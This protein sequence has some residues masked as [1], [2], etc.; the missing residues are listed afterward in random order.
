MKVRV[1]LLS[2]VGMLA[3]M[4]VLSS[5]A[6]G[7]PAPAQS[8]DGSNATSGDIIVTAQRRA[9]SIQTV[10]LSVTALNG[11]DLKARGLNDLT[12]ISLAAPSL[13]ITNNNNFSV[14][15]IGTLALATALDTSVAISLDDVNLGRP[16]LSSFPFY[17]LAQVEVLNGP[18]GLLFGKNASAGLLNVTT[19]RPQLNQL[20]ASF[21]T[22]LTSRERPGE[23][24]QG[25]IVRASLNLPVT[26]N[27]ALRIAAIYSYQQPVTRF[28][29]APPPGSDL[30]LRQ[31]GVRVKYLWN[32]P[33]DTTLYLV[34][35][36][37]RSTGIAGSLDLT[38]KSLGAG[39]PEAGPIA[40]VGI[41][42][43]SENFLTAGDAPFYRN[44][45]TGGVQGTV[46]HVFGNG[47]AL[48]NIAAWRFYDLSQN[49]DADFAPGNGLNVNS[50]QAS[51]NQFSDEL[52]LTLPQE[53]RLTGQF[54]LYYFRSVVRENIQ[55]RGNSF[56]PAAALPAFP[57]CVG[58]T[59][60]PGGP[61]NCAVNNIA[62]IGLD[63]AFTMHTESLAAFGQLSYRIADGL[64]M[65][66]GGRVTGDRVSIDLLANQQ[67]YFV[68]LGASGL[69][70]QKYSDT[71]FSFKA[72]PQYQ[73]T[74]TIMAYVNYGQGYK[75][76]GFNTAPDSPTSNLTV[77]PETTKSWEGGMKSQ[78][79]DKKITLNVS[80][81]RTA[82]NNYQ[83]QSFNIATRS[84]I[85]QNAAS[86][87]SKGIELGFVGRPTRNLTI[88]GQATFLD[89]RFKQYIGAQCYVG[90]PDPGC[91]TTGTFNG[92]GLIAPLAPKF[93]TSWD[94]TYEHQL[95]PG[96]TGFVEG[97]VY[98]RSKIYFQANHA[99][100]AVVDPMDIFGASIGVHGDAWSAS[101]FCKNCTNRVFPV[102]ISSVP[103]DAGTR[104]QS[105]NQVFD[106][107]S[108]RTIGL[109]L[110]Y[111]M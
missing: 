90:Q 3:A 31:Y 64:T 17:D 102:N 36:Y 11:Q 62:F 80:L 92:A 12:Q 57:F 77:Y 70:N 34:A 51:Y 111:K 68:R 108:V 9:E 35:D 75:G 41:V 107:N 66:A 55:L 2:N 98:H 45:K 28:V 27:S 104:I 109:R 97:N 63:R 23:N 6:S 33:G 65:V 85:V 60:A 46:S 74:P 56:T 76:P 78:F 14:R 30:D 93:A 5:P 4:G 71:N 32:A 8:G 87:V 82:F 48:S 99:P 105:Y 103:L 37:N 29:G 44:L 79:L 110:S 73:I 25:A 67:P 89:A 50:D 16:L 95:L 106:F 91:A 19:T 18:Q 1:F 15:G 43:G 96:V 69:Y 88:N 47:M 83:A 86:L 39:S 81:F 84:Y 26:D 72:G 59:V 49:N 61:P 94:A 58:A 21:D 24:A 53:N 54:G 40:S 38:Y 7:Q 22:E 52:R 20:G 101:I 100:G 42:P 10:P 13:Q